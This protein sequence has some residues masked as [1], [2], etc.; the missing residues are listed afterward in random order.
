MTNLRER[1]ASFAASAGEEA[2]TAKPISYFGGA[3]ADMVEDL[4]DGQ[5]AE[6]LEIGCGSGATGRLAILRGKCACYCGV[7][8]NARAALNA[9]Q[10]LHEVVRGDIET[11][12]L[13]WP[14]ERFD[15]L[16]LSEVLE[17]LADPWRVLQKIHPVLKRGALVLAGSPNASHYRVILMLLR[18]EWQL[19]DSGVMDRSH[20]RWF[21]PKSYPR[22]FEQT[23]YEILSTEG[24]GQ[25]GIKARIA[26]K[27]LFRRFDWLWARQIK[28]KARR[29]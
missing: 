19:A 29:I 12:D 24:L 25:D 14:P 10:H 4:P 17:H 8:L 28:V 15:V 23:G 6:I 7:E 13:P 26:S 16:I 27:L 21:T 11:L 18:G 2:Y 22:L 9:A 5:N 1:A 20:L 3:R